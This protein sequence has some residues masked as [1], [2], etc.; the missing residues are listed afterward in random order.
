[1]DV[2]GQVRLRPVLSPYGFH[3]EDG[4]WGRETDEIPTVRERGA[5]AQGYVVGRHDPRDLKRA[6]G[7]GGSDRVADGHGYSWVRPSQ[8]VDAMA[9]HGD[10][11]RPPAPPSALYTGGPGVV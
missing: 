9:V 10:G 3:L 1:R 11:A 2:Q 4:R 5:H 6:L 8:N 7:I